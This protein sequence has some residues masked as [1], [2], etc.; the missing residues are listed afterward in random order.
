[1]A[2]KLIRLSDENETLVE[3]EIGQQEARP[4]SGGVADK[5]EASFDRVR[6]LLLSIC[7]PLT[8]T[9]KQLNKEMDIDQVEVEVGLSFEGEGNIFITK[10]TAGAN[11]KVKLSLRPKV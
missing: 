5:V 10:T 9:W 4:I 7:R 1:M 8:E 3:V 6:S 11:L 2:T